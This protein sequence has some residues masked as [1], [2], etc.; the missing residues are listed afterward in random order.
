MTSKRPAVSVVARAE[1]EAR[2]FFI[3]RGTLAQLKVYPHE[4]I[5]LADQLVDL[6]EKEEK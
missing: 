6:A 4:L 2:A 3:R 1:G 5:A